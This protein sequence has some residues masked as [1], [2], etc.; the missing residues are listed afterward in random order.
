[1]ADG[2]SVP[3]GEAQQRIEATPEEPLSLPREGGP[4]V[5]DQA[6]VDGMNAG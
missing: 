4:F 1:M 6:V 5:L 2:G 3:I